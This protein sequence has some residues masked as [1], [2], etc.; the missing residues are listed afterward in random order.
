MRLTVLTLSGLVL[1]ALLGAG[2]AAPPTSKVG[3]LLLEPCSCSVGGAKANLKIGALSRKEQ[4]YVGDYRFT[5]TPYFFKNEK[6][7]FTI[8]VTDDD[9]RRFIGG[10]SV[11]F[12]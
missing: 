3:E 1:L 5:V 4:G 10:M 7:T 12:T 9:V 8:A 6:G 11:D 2:K